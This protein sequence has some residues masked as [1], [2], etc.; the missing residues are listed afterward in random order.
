MTAGE[1][2]I[3][4]VSSEST[5]DEGKT[6]TTTK[7]YVVAKLNITA[8]DNLVEQYSDTVLHEMKDDEFSA[9]IAA[10]AG[11]YAVTENAEAIRLYTIDKLIG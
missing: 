2:K 4:T 7:E 3:I 1:Y 8:Y 9:K 6:V 11:A 10:E 5:D